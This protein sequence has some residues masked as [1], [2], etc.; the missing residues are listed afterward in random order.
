ML[1]DALALSPLA[2][3]QA[4]KLSGGE[5]ARMALARLLMRPYELLILDEPTAAMDMEF[6]AKSEA[7][8]YDYCRETGCAVLIVTHSVPQA[9][10]LSD[11][12]LF[13]RGGELW[14]HGRTNKLLSAPETPELLQFLDFC[15]I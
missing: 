15:G 4:Q 1:M 5:T 2:D 7:L 11:S 3:R 6:T 9:R 12:L 8:I 10:R 14:E 13:F